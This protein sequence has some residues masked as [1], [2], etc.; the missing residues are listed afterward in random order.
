MTELGMALEMDLVP[1]HERFQAAAALAELARQVSCQAQ[2]GIQGA[3]YV[4][5]ALAR[6]G[7]ID[8]A[9][10]FFTQHSYPGGMHWLDS[11]ATTLLENW[12]GNQS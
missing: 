6:N 11:G 3:R 8:T 10:R 9:W 7:H 1:E 12:E 5:R 4:P 2:F